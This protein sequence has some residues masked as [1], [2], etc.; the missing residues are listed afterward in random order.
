MA[1]NPPVNASTNKDICSEKDYTDLIYLFTQISF[2]I[3]NS[4]IRTKILDEFN[5]KKNS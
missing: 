3:G 1:T 5:Y 2:N 4:T